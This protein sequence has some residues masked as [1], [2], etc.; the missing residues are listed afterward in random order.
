MKKTIIPAYASLL[1][2]I[3]L[4]GCESI[5]P[6]TAP[7][8]P[9]VNFSSVSDKKPVDS[10]TAINTMIT[11]LITSQIISGADDAPSVFFKPSAL[12]IDEKSKE[13]YSFIFNNYALSVYKN[14][15]YSEL[16][17]A[18]TSMVDY[19]YSLS[20]YYKEN[21]IFRN[22]KEGK[23]YLWSLSLVSTKN[24]K[25]SAWDYSLNVVVP[26]KQQNENT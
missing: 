14:L 8:G 15:L 2:I 1:L 26:E 19:D 7:I 4:S 5:P 21:P 18:P 24:N 10:K 11:A 12:N 22:I 23:V 16:I 6:G 9:I 25:K 3:L 20:S 17:T 13:D